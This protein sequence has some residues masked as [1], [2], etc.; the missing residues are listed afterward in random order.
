M[1]SNGNKSKNI[2][3]EVKIIY[4]DGSKKDEQIDKL[5]NAL[6]T[7]KIIGESVVGIEE[8]LTEHFPKL[9]KDM[10]KVLKSPVLNLK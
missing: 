9:Q 2:Q 4:I 7:I 8:F 1:V 6:E 10:A 5:V 3:R